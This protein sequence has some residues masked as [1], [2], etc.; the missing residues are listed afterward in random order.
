MASTYGSLIRHYRIYVGLLDEPDGLGTEELNALVARES[1]AAHSWSPV[2]E[3]EIRRI[4]N[5]LVAHW[6]QFIDA[7]PVRD[8]YDRTHWWWFLHEGPQ[9]REEA[10]RLQ[11]ELG[12]AA[13]VA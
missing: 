13:A 2:E 5:D 6:E 11:E 12:K 9:V 3:S 10:Q 8:M 4:D 1:V 7:I